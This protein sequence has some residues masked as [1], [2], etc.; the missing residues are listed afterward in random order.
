MTDETAA[1]PYVWRWRRWKPPGYDQY[2]VHVFAERFAQPCRVLA[3]GRTMNSVAVEFASDRLTAVVS[4]RA[5]RRATSTTH[6]FIFC[7]YRSG[8]LTLWARARLS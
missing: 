6:F 1:Y 2:L 8:G 4:S 5:L 7:V 3:R